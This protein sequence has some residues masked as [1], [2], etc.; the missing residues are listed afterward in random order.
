MS[1]LLVSVVV[2]THDRPQRLVRLLDGLRGQSLAR[3]RFEVI[4]VDDG[5]GPAT[6]ETLEG[7]RR[8]GGLGLRVVRH[9]GARGPGAARNRGW[10]LARAPLVAFTDD[11]CVPAPNWLAAALQ[12]AA[13]PG[14]IVQ[15]R[16]EPDPGELGHKLLLARTVRVAT[17]GPQYETC[18]IFYPRVVLE[19]LGGFDEGFGLRPGGEDTDLAWR[20]LE[21]GCAATFA[22]AAVVFHAVARLGILGTLQD[23]TRWTASVRLFR[24]HPRARTILHR[25]CFWNVWHYLLWR[26]LLALLGPR[27]LRRLVLTRH[28]LALQARGRAAGAG[29]WAVPFLLVHDLLETGAIVRGAARYR[30]LVL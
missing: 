26:S 4:V 11:D 12:A 22:P 13:S 2:P 7:E 25:R 6:G 9:D 17:L 3:E 20:A 18:N 23:A 21:H 5:S 8:R 14:A 28:A 30:T 1:E 24:Q 15:G 27:W 10:R 29:V 19:S 16:T